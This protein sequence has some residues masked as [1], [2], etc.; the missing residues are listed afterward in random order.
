MLVISRGLIVFVSIYIFKN[1]HLMFKIVL[2][3]DVFISVAPVT[4]LQILCNGS[5]LFPLSTKNARHHYYVL[6]FDL[7]DTP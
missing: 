6:S 1:D 4:L 3:H 2:T 5:K 7:K